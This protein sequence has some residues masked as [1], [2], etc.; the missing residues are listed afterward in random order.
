MSR[1]RSLTFRVSLS[2]LLAFAVLFL[3]LLTIGVTRMLASGFGDIDRGLRTSA[4][5]FLAGIDPIEADESTQAVLRMFERLQQ[6]T[7]T[8]ELKPLSHIVAIRRINQQYFATQGTPTLNA[9]SLVPGALRFQV[10]GHVYRGFM[11][12]GQR[13]DVLFLDREDDR[14]QEVIFETALELA[15]YMTIALPL[16]VLPVW[17]AVRAG[18][19]PLRAL[20][21]QIAARDPSDVSPVRS[22]S[23]YAELMPLERA[24]NLQFRNAADR[25]H[26]EQA[27][28][29]DAAHELRTP[30]AAIAT[31]AHVL[32]LSEGHARFEALRRLESA[33]ERCSHLVQQLLSLA[34][35]DAQAKRLGSDCQGEKF[36]LMDLLS[37][38]LVLMEPFARSSNCELSLEGPEHAF[39][40]ADKELL[41][42][43]VV[44]LVDNALKY[45]S[46]GGCVEVSL[47]KDTS[48]WTLSV[49]DQGP[50][51][52]EQ[53]QERTF[54]RFWRQPG[55]TV[56]GTGL[57]LAIVREVMHGIGGEAQLTH[58]T[59]GGCVALARWPI[60]RTSDGSRVPN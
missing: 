22:E 6:S 39:I 60:V 15:G 37:D 4:E 40:R 29:H 23:S 7:T 20:S 48:F 33:I 24:L 36:D 58:R 43:V 46:A 59:G 13:W 57:G 25:I 27:F 41:R 18:M 47:A 3:V 50:G 9:I 35:A 32:A 42:S 45:G 17:L 44:N 5:A 51:V 8:D 2:L 38:T 54:E 49:A 26:R 11:A 16:L 10:N 12:R 30:L 56:Q 19:R 28:V 53:D 34:R 52:N 1:S 21:A 14:L 31:Q 55:Q